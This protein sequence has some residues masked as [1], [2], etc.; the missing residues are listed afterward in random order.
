MERMR[1]NSKSFCSHSQVSVL[2]THDQAA[3]GSGSTSLKVRLELHQ[4][5]CIDVSPEDQGHA[6]Y[7]WPNLPAVVS[8]V[9]EAQRFLA[10]LV[11]H[12]YGPHWNGF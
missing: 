10:A 7:F 8:S 11:F 1:R 2:T 5:H 9:S 6:P 4:C 3:D 12:S